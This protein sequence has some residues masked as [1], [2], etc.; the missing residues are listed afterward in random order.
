MYSKILEP[1]KIIFGIPVKD[2]QKKIFYFDIWHRATVAYVR[3]CSIRA[4]YTWMSIFSPTELA[5]VGRRTLH[6]VAVG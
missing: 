5:F 3:V 1:L 2:C 4:L 6:S